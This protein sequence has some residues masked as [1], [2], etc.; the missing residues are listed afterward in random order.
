M[1]DTVLRE[2]ALERIADALDSTGAYQVA[3]RFR[4]R[5]R[6]AEDDGSPTLTGLFVDVE[7]T[8]LDTKDDAI[9]QLALVPFEYSPD[10]GRVF[11]VGEAQV[12]LEDP[13]RPVPPAVTALTGIS[14][15]RGG[16]ADRRRSGARARWRRPLGDRP[17]RGLRP[18]HDGAAPGRLS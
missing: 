18:A 3:R 9:I 10:D 13:G 2:A 17:Q 14:E 8:G 11:G 4:P 1:P 12:H 15:R 6:Y 16:P 7:T 5:A